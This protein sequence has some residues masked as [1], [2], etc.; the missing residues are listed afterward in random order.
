MEF[1]EILS[2]ILGSSL[3]TSVI[4]NMFFRWKTNKKIVVNFISNFRLSA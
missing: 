4:T 1:G 2:V 3:I